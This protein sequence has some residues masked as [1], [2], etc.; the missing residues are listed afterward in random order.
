MDQLFSR[1]FQIPLDFWDAMAFCLDQENGRLISPDNAQDIDS[2]EDLAHLSGGLY[3][4]SGYWSIDGKF[5]FDAA[6]DEDVLDRNGGSVSFSPVKK[7]GAHIEPRLCIANGQKLRRSD[8]SICKGL[9]PYSQ[10]Y[11]SQIRKIF[12]T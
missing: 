6:S 11:L 5:W 8:F 4:T 12:V 2:N 10:N 9:G 1:P 3:R 7:W